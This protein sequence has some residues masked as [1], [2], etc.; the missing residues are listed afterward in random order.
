MDHTKFPINDENFLKSREARSLRILSEYISP[1]RCFTHQNILH[2]V[3]FFGSARFQPKNKYY[4]A[5]E[6]LAHE[7]TKL[8][9]ELE[10]ETGSPF[11][12][13][14]G[15]GPGIMEAANKGSANESCESIGL[16]IELPHEQTCNEFISPHLNSQFNYFFM[17]K[18]WFLY[19]AK[20]V[21]VFPGGF[22]TLDELFETLTLVQ[23]HKISKGNIPILLYDKEFWHK[24]INFDMLVEMELIS[25]ED[26]ELLTFFENTEEALQILKPKLADL[27]KTLTF[28]HKI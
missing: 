22:G 11:H 28:Y 24:L 18:F 1:D 16:C 19:H 14:T 3:V 13:C 5:A 2:T 20:A 10:K 25:K 4:I 17:R 7:L 15:G 23:T 26:L 8:S 21:V 6:N 27:M 9:K 12:I